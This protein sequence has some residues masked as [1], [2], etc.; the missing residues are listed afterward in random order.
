MNKYT[1]LELSKKLFEAG[2]P[3]ES[4]YHWVDM[5]AGGPSL[6]IQLSSD[7]RNSYTNLFDLRSGEKYDTSEIYRNIEFDS[8]DILNDICVEY[9]KKFFGN[10][11][12]RSSA[13]MHLLQN[14]KKQEAEDYIWKNCLFNPKNK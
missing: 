6:Y 7:T 1:S 4:D 2:C 9:S 12:F 8:Y 10:E 3:I 13:I 11:K 5:G 14:N